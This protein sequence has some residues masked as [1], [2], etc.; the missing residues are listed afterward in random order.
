MELQM[1]RTPTGEHCATYE[2]GKPVEK[3]LEMVKQILANPAV[4][5]SLV[6]H[7]LRVD[8]DVLNSLASLVY[9]T[10]E[11][12]YGHSYPGEPVS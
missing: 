10:E 3:G 1:F 5:Q 9:R 2:I 7:N 12:L 6:A 4:I 11:E 8:K